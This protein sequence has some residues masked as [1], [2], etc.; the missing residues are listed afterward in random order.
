MHAH[1]LTHSK[2]LCN[3]VEAKWAPKTGKT[4]KPDDQPALLSVTWILCFLPSF[5]FSSL[6][7]LTFYS[8]FLLF[9]LLFLLL[10]LLSFD[11]FPCSVFRAL[12]H[13][14]PL[15]LFP[16]SPQGED[17]VQLAGLR[18]QDH[19]EAVLSAGDHR[20]APSQCRQLHKA[21]APATQRPG[22]AGG[23]Q[24]VPVHRRPGGEVQGQGGE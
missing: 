16:P 13:F 10:L 18:P 4:I 2:S 8:F 17:Q 9:L 20:G 5:P 12:N 19:R 15:P 24:T 14:S 6:S 1:T 11:S 7:L 23:Q 3:A 21:A 22:H